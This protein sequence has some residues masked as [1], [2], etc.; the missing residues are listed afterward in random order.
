M[1]N[2]IPD[3]TIEKISKQADIVEVISEYVQLKKQG[4][5]YFGLCPFHGE[6]SPSFSV[7]AEKQIFHCFGCGAGGNVFS[8]IMDLEKCS[9]IEAVKIV[10]DKLKIDVDLDDNQNVVGFG[11]SNKFLSIYRAH[12]L[13]Q[14]FYHHFLVNTKEGSEALQYLRKRGF[15]DEV[16]DKF[17]IGY[18]PNSW[19]VVTRFLHK[20]GFDVHE[21]YQAGLVNQ[22]ESDGNYFDRFRDRIMFPIWD[23][24]SRTIA[25]GGRILYE[26]EPKYLNSPETQ[27]FNKGKILYGLNIARSQIRK[28]QQVVLFEGYVDVIS[29]WRAGVD[30]G[31]ATLGTALTEE[32]ATLIR[33]NVDN[34]IICYDSDSAGIN[35]AYRAAGILQNA[36]CNVKIAKMPDGYDPDD[37]IQQYG[38]ESFNTNVI[39]AS[40]TLMTFK[41]DYLKRGKNL[42]NEGE[43][44]KYIEEVL[45]EISQLPK[46][47]ERDHYLRQISNEY[48]LSLDA[49]KSQQ[50]QIYKSLR[51][52]KD[53]STFNRNNNSNYQFF[54]KKKL[55]PAY[56]NAERL[57]LAHMIRDVNIAQQ[58]KEQIGC[59][60]NIDE[61]NA[62]ALVVYGFYEEGV[63]PTFGNI[64]QKLDDEHIKRMVS[65]IAMLD[66]NEDITENELTDYIKQVMNH[67]KWLKIKEIEKEKETAEKQQDHLKAAQ[68]AMQIIQMKKELK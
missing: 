12:D 1:G 61:H 45:T 22:R 36:G 58:I 63:A 27:I 3:E 66:I 44:I 46:A 53:I 17:Q 23:L 9:F 38:I 50:T 2:R 55:L 47:V 60:F 39:N 19:D 68:I 16:I 31:I 57:L 33:R 49:L 56:H 8:F 67:P 51:K 64:I 35:A 13:L 29:A 10:A 62:I 11:S 21:M 41:F 54:A 14:K 32:Q 52:N 59:G 30:N 15:T 28:K 65:E 5:N 18:A 26:G 4:R 24:Q 34:V 42:Q 40:I 7:S 43:L 6:K 37:Y 20:R 25:F 48:S